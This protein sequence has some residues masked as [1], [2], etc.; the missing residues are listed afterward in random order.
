MEL[1]LKNFKFESDT[2]IAFIKHIEGERKRELTVV[3]AFTE[4]DVFSF[5]GGYLLMW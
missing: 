3:I 5:V 4:V 1:C 2:I